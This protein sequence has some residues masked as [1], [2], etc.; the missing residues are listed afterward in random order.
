MQLSSATTRKN[1]VL[2]NEI[3][4]GGLDNPPGIRAS[5]TNLSITRF[6]QYQGRALTLCLKQTGSICYRNQNCKITRSIVSG[7]ILPHHIRREREKNNLI[8]TDLHSFPTMTRDAQASWKIASLFLQPW[9]S[10]KPN[11]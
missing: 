11:V 7:S 9:S 10:S 5:T 3:S 1:E 6:F 8:I 2:M 4:T